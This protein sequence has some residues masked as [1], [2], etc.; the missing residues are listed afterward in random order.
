M[1]TGEICALQFLAARRPSTE[2]RYRFLPGALTA[3]PDRRAIDKAQSFRKFFR[4]SWNAGVTNPACGA[5]KKREEKLSTVERAMKKVLFGLIAA[6]TV[7]VA[8]PA[9][10]QVWFHAGP[11]AARIGPPPP[12]GWRHRHFV[13]EYAYAVPECRFIRE[14]IR[15]PRGRIIIRDREVCD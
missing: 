2:D 15:T 7:V 6:A 4:F 3:L 5:L 12:W 8:A 13:R 9:S 1:G 14:R 10:A 11:V